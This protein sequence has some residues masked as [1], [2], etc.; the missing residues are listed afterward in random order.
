MSNRREYNVTVLNRADITTFPKLGVS[1]MRKHITY[2]AAGLPPSTVMML[3]DEW[4]IEKEKTAIRED[5][6]KRIKNK[7]ESYRV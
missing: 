4:T 2:V 1:E 3:A 7:P 5:I 6:E